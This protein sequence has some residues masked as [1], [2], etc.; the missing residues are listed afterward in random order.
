M[1]NGEMFDAGK[2]TFADSL[3]YRTLASG[4][5]VFG[6][7]GIM[8]DIFVPLDTSVLYRYYN[9]LQR[10]N[11]VYNYVID[12][13]DQNRNNILKQYP[14]FQKF[15][16]RYAVTGE[17]VEELI[18]RGE[19]EKIPRDEESI[20]FTLPIIKKEIKALIARDIYAKDHFYQ[21]Y[22]HDDTMIMKALELIRNQDKYKQ[23]LASTN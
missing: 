18:S 11:I 21:I 6:G 13:V 23:I 8:P 19:K 10:N 16:D 14:L 1:E 7:G 3:R 2:I 12:Y 20:S 22:N 15:A 5:T 17:M 9:R 4:R